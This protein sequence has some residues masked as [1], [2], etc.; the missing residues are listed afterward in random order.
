M[1]EEAHDWDV[2]QAKLGAELGWSNK[3]LEGRKSRNSETV[4]RVSGERL[5]GK[6]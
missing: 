4:D 2:G 5:E 3:V 1:Q 6:V